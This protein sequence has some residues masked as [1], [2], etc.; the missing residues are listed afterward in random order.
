MNVTLT[1]DEVAVRVVFAMTELS[2]KPTH[3]PTGKQIVRRVGPTW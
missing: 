1:I 2:L 3:Q